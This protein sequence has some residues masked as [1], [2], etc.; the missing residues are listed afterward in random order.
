MEDYDEQNHSYR[1]RFQ[2]GARTED[3]MFLLLKN[4]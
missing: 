3:E 2:F 1:Q 4:E